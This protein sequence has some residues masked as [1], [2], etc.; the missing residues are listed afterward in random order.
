MIKEKPDHHDAELVLKLYDL[1]REATMRQA[2]TW[3]AMKFN[4]DTIEDVAKAMGG[5]DSASFRMVTSY[6]DMAA[7]LVNNGAIDEQMFNDANG[8]HVIVLAKIAPFLEEYRKRMGNPNYLRQ[9]EKLVMKM[10]N[11]HQALASVR[12]RFKQMAAAQAGR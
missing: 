10:P 12:E 7:S 3:Y 1:R 11:A 5:A 9:L 2:R 8:E 4:P 6:W